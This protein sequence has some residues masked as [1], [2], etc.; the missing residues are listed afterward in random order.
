MLDLH[1]TIVAVRKLGRW[2]RWKLQLWPWAKSSGSNDFWQGR[3]GTNWCWKL[4]TQPSWKTPAFMWYTLVYVSMI[5]CNI[6]Y[7][8]WYN[9]LYYDIYIHILWYI[10]T[11]IYI[12]NITWYTIIYYDTLYDIIS[13][14]FQLFLVE[15]RSR[16]QVREGEPPGFDAWS[17]GS[18]EVG[19]GAPGKNPQ[20]MGVGWTWGSLQTKITT[21]NHHLS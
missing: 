17:P 6:I 1:V 12:Y 9:M 16:S 21:E 2:N 14:I 11:H 10:M 19:R 3:D 8:L 7:I 18:P 4:G 15:H 5:R 13:L 20:K